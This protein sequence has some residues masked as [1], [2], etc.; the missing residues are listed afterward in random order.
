M[1]ETRHY[2]TCDY[3]GKRIEVADVGVYPKGWFT[4]NIQDTEETRA[5][6][7]CCSPKC[8]MAICADILGF[9]VGGFPHK[10][11]EPY[12]CFNCGKGIREE[13]M[14]P[15]M[16]FLLARPVCLECYPKVD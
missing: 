13:D 8:A 4:V 15:D 16:K 7:D 3:C 14:P 5:D 10:E 1:E 2:Y 6:S 9:P 11:G 12:E